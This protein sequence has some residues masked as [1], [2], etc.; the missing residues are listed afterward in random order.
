MDTITH[1]KNVQKYYSKR[2]EDYDGQKVTTWK[3]KQGFG[4]EILNGVTDALAGLE[5]KPVL[6][7]GV[8]SGRIGFPLLEKVKPWLVG[9]DLSKKTLELAKA[10][11]SHYKQRFDLI[12]GDAEHLPFQNSVFNGIVCISI[13]HYFVFPE[14]SLAEFSRTLKE[15]GVF[16]YG[17]ITMHELDSQQ[18]LDKLEKTL[19]QAHARYCWPSEMRRLLENQGFL[20]SKIKVIP[21]RKSYLSLMGDREKYFDVKPET[22][23]KC[24]RDA[25]ANEMKLYLIGSKGLTLF[26][27]LI[28]ALEGSRS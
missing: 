25:T 5:N 6:E 3:S 16:A 23:H 21:Y 17:D 18:F 26:Y 10:R 2:A 4:A 24:I 13:M 9:L 27:T 11:M 1:K 12:L 20:F 19:S 14:R 28:A 8:G 22:L 7:V 15:G